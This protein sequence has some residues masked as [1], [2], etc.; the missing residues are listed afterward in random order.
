[1]RKKYRYTIVAFVGIFLILWFSRNPNLDESSKRNKGD[2]NAHQEDGDPQNQKKSARDPNARGFREKVREF[3]NQA[4]AEMFFYGRVVDQDGNG[5]EGAKINYNVERAGAL[6]ADNS[7]ANNN[8]KRAAISLGGGA[9]SIEG[10]RGLT[11]RI[12]LIEKVGYRDSGQ[13][14]RSFGYRGTP[15]IHNADPTAPVDFLL[16]SDSASGTKGLFAK[17]IK[18]S[19]NQGPVD[20]LIPP[21]GKFTLLPTRNKEPG[22]IRDFDWNIEVSMDQAELVK[23]DIGGAE[24]APKDGYQKNFRYGSKQG[25]PKWEG[26]IQERY[27]FKTSSGLYGVIN[28]HLVARRPDGETQGSLEIRINETGSRNLAR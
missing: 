19:W 6:M 27:A 28:L 4:D 15:E 9:F 24:L 17:E 20:F 22:R 5:I 2:R 10:E 11:L 25:S 8:S 14:A 12:G 18:F 3:Y 1:M 26:A 7:V 13:S 16:V 23:L 21:V